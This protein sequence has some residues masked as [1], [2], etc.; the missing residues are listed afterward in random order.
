MRTTLQINDH[1]YRGAKQ[2]AVKTHRTLTQ[3]VEDALRLSLDGPKNMS[4][5]SARALPTFKGLGLNPGLDLD[6]SNSLADAM[7]GHDS[8]GR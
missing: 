1:L 6:D 4:G 7:E 5:R 2:L 3:V 8:S